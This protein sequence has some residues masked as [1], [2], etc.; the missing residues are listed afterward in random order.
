MLGGL[1]ALYESIGGVLGL[2]SPWKRLFFGGLLGFSGQMIVKPSISYNPDG[3]AK[4]FGET[5][6]PWY[7]WVIAPGL[8]FSLFL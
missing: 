5:L 6:F 4:K 1:I 2:G 7:A 8:V 3:S